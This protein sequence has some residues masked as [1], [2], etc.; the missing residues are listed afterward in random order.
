M[1]FKYTQGHCNSCDQV[2]LISLLLS[3]IA[4]S[5]LEFDSR[6]SRPSRSLQKWYYLSNGAR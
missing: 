2:N 5:E 3:R 4:K 6:Y 1:T